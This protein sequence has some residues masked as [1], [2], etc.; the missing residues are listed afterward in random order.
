MLVYSQNKT[1]LLFA[2]I[3]QRSQTFSSSTVKLGTL[4]TWIICKRPLQHIYLQC[5]A[6]LTMV[7]M[8]KMY[9]PPAAKVKTKNLLCWTAHTSGTT[10]V[11]QILSYWA[12]LHWGDSCWIVALI[13][14][15]KK[16][17]KD[18]NIHCASVAIPHSCRKKLK[19]ADILY[20]FILLK[21]RSYFK[22]SYVM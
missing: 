8:L 19:K 17:Q 1:I 21:C 13:V 3:L 12:Q 10:E 22:G 15:K 6:P 14:T 2:W 11:T 7:W 9:F 18:K 20:R 4:T 16:S 5:W